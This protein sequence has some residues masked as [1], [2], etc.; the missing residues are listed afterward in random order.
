MTVIE[1]FMGNNVK[2]IDLEDCMFYINNII[3]EKHNMKSDFLDNVDHDAVL[4]Y[5]KGRFFDFKPEYEYPIFKILINIS[6]DDLNRI[7]YKN[8]IYKFNGLRKIRMLLTK[9]L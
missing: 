2:F 5:L 9:V 8:N 6:Q 1:N 4:D 3:S 7:Y